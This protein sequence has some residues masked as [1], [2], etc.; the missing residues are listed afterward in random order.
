MASPIEQLRLSGVHP[1][2]DEP[3]EQ[4]A[5]IVSMLLALLRDRSLSL[6]WYQREFERSVRQYARDL[7]HLRQLGAGF[8]MKISNQKVGRVSLVSFSAKGRLTDAP[9]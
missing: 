3:S 4:V 6:A 5:R 2:G 1:E 8:G 9:S 7:R